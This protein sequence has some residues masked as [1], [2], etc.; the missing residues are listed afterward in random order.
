MLRGSALAVSC[1][2]ARDVAQHV[3]HN[4]RAEAVHAADG[5]DAAAQRKLASRLRWAAPWR[6][7]YDFS[8]QP[9]AHESLIRELAT[10]RFVDDIANA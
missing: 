2:S 3:E 7:D 5:Y 6:L 10:L 1:R 9:G 8:A 4:T